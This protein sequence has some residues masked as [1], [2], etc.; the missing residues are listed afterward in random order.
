MSTSIDAST[1][2][3]NEIQLV[4]LRHIACFR[5]TVFPAL[6]RL[7]ELA[8]RRPAD[9]KLALAELRQIGLIDFAPLHDRF[10][11]WYLQP[12]GAR[13]CGLRPTCSGPLS[14]TGKIRAYAMLRF[15]CLQERP[16]RPLS[17]DEVRSISPDWQ[18]P[19]IPPGYY[20]DP[21]HPGRVGFCRID[22]GRR[23][24]WDRIVRT[25][26]TD[27]ATH[28]RR[29]GFRRLMRAER[30]EITVLTVFQQKARR[31]LE[32]FDGGPNGA[33]GAVRVQTMTELLPLII[34][35]N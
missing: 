15:C 29:I 19:G 6:Q 25:V 13:H 35:A 30:F 3:L 12:A 31:L 5:M 2:V 26:R 33:G 10:R 8:G 24:R 9:L 22:A 4:T 11:Y 23:G 14:E 20:F 18:R 1:A 28:G 16:R 17:A 27:L 32:C 21:G 34:S 7:P